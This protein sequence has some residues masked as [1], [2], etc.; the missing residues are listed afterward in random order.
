MNRSIRVN[1]S[2]NQMQV[3]CV[4]L[5]NILSDLIIIV[6]SLIYCEKYKKKRKFCNKIID[7]CIQITNN[8]KESLL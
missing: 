6:I 4:G 2:E 3:S 1:D 5:A 8:F 7:Y